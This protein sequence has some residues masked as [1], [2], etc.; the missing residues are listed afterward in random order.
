[1][2][3]STARQLTPRKRAVGTR[4]RTFNFYYWL[5][6]HLLVIHVLLLFS[7]LN[8]FVLPFGTLY[9]FVQ[10]GIVKNQLLHVYAKNYEANGQVILIRI[11][12]Y[13]LDG[14]ILTQAVFLAYMVVLKKTVNVG[15]SACLIILTTLTKLLMT[16]MCRAQFEQDDIEE[17]NI[18][19]GNFHSEADVESS[20]NQKDSDMSGT[21]LINPKHHRQS[22]ILTWKLPEWLN[23]SYAS[24]QHQPHQ[25]RR[26]PNPFHP[27]RQEF[28]RLQSISDDEIRQDLHQRGL[29]VPEVPS[30][31]PVTEFPW[32][33]IPLG[34]D[35]VGKKLDPSGPVVS[36][37]PPIPWDDQT[38]VDLP[39]DNPFYTRTFHNVLWLPRN[40]C[41]ILDL[42]E[43][44]DLKV[45]L[46][47]DAA[48]G[49]L[50]T[51]LGLVEV[52]SPEEAAEVQSSP[53]A[54]QLGLSTTSNPFDGTEEIDLPPVIAQR[55][56]SREG[57]VEQTIRPR[58]PTFRRKLS[59][60]TV[61]STATQ[62]PRRP[63]VLGDSTPSQNF[64][65]FSD[66]KR[67]TT[68]GRARSGSILSVLQYPHLQRA[69][70]AEPHEFGERPTFHLQP[71]VIERPKNASN[72]HL[73][74]AS[75]TRS[76]NISAR[77]AIFNEVMAEEKAALID[78]IEDE[79]AQTQKATSTKSW[80][81]AWMFRRPE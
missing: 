28:A 12:R 48:A 75:R 46:C 20:G 18:M 43:T 36:H 73:S 24:L 65:S 44:V 47:V 22:S 23:F 41:G 21:G 40:P 61:S 74:V 57:D 67:P 29:H 37:P 2:Y 30:Q 45:S 59:S 1:M 54:D 14:L 3:P 35:N 6:N 5:P 78:R 38:T 32:G 27:Q 10:T 69:K 80:M 76:H 71:E 11:L 72:P 60:L 13:S 9:F 53:S 42:D 77:E 7:V 17:A 19:C 81:T 26:Q 25:Q 16:R 8:P 62:D 31:T 50:G 58:R 49:Q 33:G 63:S 70:S 34:N 56:Q 68:A 52:T 4:P 39:Y 66:G 55:V 79:E 64:R 15:L 51:W